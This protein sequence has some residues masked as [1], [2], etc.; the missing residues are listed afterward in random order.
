[1]ILE[2]RNPAMPCLLAV[3][4]TLV[5]Y[6]RAFD[7]NDDDVTDSWKIPYLARKRRWI[8]RSSDPDDIGDPVH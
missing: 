6:V 3:V 1:M 2:G 4:Q 8:T 5:E 7:S